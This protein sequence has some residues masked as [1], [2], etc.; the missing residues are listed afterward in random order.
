MEPIG[1]IGSFCF[2]I[3]G[4]PQ[5]FKSYKD[6]HSDGI[7]WSFLLLWLF[8][9]IFTLIY[10]MP[11]GHLPLIFNYLGNMF[12]VAIILYYKISPRSLK[13]LQE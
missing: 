4:V 13:I 8:G 2:A 6:G 5:A 12:L 10:V 11:K 1:W 3:C 9:E 7:S